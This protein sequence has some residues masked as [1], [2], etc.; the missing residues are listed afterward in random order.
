MIF[1]VAMLILMQTPDID[2]QDPSNQMEMTFCAHEDFVDADALMNAQWALTS[3]EMKLRDEGFD[4]S[5]DD[6]PGYFETLLDAQRAWLA[7]RDA[8]CLSE[9]YA[10]RGGSMEPMLVSGCKAHLTRLRTAELE[11]LMI[12]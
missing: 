3:A 6:R 2:C 10:A 7:Y 12:P 1:T 9:G 8:H 11:Q 4:P 5:W